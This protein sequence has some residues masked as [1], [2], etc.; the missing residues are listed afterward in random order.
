MGANGQLSYGHIWHNLKGKLSMYRLILSFLLCSVFTTSFAEGWHVSEIPLG[1]SYSD[2][3]ELT[4]L[5]ESTSNDAP[6]GGLMFDSC[7]STE[8]NRLALVFDQLTNKL[9]IVM[10]L[11]QLDFQADYEVLENQLLNRYGEP[12]FSGTNPDTGR[13]YCFGD[14]NEQGY[15]EDD[16]R[17]V[18][19]FVTV[20]DH[21]QTA[22]VV[23]AADRLGM[24]K[25]EENAK[26]AKAAA[27]IKRQQQLTT[28]D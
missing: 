7:D 2:A 14:C 3:S 21:G 17:G 26:A 25:L 22:I 19:A 16:G 23:S 5:K 13:Q 8:A 1:M 28:L 4:C 18:I 15:L 20:Y 27:T 10:R 11:K 9:V 12:A 6:A 24:E